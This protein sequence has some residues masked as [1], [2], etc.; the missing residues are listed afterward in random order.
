MTSNP[1]KQ[2]GRAIL[3]ATIF[4]LTLA[5]TFPRLGAQIATNVRMPAN[6]RG[7]QAIEALADR[8]PDVARAH[9]LDPQRLATMLRTQPSLGVDVEGRL[10]FAC[11]G[12]AVRPGAA[13]RDAITPSSSFAQ[14][15]AG[16]A[17]DVF[18]LH[19][20]PGATRVIYLDFTGHTTSGT[21]WN[22]SFTGGATIVSAPFDLDG[23]ST[24][25]NDAERGAILAIWKRVAEDYAPFLVDVTTQDPGVESLRKTTTGDLAY[26]IRVVISPTN[27]Y[28][29][30]AGG[31]AY[32]GSFSWNSDTPAWVFTNQLANDAGYI[33]EATSHE[34]GH[35][36]GLNHDGQGG[37]S[38]TE[39]Y[40]G[41][42]DWAPIMG[43][44]Y[45]RGIVQFSRG[46]YA[47]ANN[48]EDDFAI[49]ATH[50]PLASDDHGNN[51][52]TATV[53]SGAAI[54]D[55]GTIETRAD[56]DVFR[57]DTGNGAIAINVVSPS[58]SPNLLLK[59]ELLNSS[60]QVLLTSTPS[61]VNVSFT[62][63]LAAGS[64]FLR[65]SALGSGD[66]LTTGY[67]S[68]GSVGNYLITG[69]LVPTTARQ[70]PVAV[71]SASSVVGTGTLSVNFS[72]QNSTDADGAI[73]SYAWN[74]GN[75]ST[76]S[77]MNAT[78]LYTAPGTYNAV[79]T[80]T[81]ND[82]LTG[83]TTVVIT[84]NAAANQAPVAIISTN[85]NA[86]TAPVAIAFSGASS[87]DP[88]GSVASYLWNFGD[89]TTSTAVTPAK[90]YS[91][92]GN[93]TVTLRV[94]DNLGA[95]ATATSVVAIAADPNAA[96]DVRQYAL[97][98]ST[99][100]SGTK[101][102]ATISIR[103]RLDRPV[104]DVTVTVQ[105]SGLVTG[106]VSGKTNIDG[107]VVIASVRTKKAGT[108][109]GTITAVASTSGKYYDSL[110]YSEPT[111]R[112]VSVK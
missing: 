7:A 16:T 37:T 103:D 35:S 64:Y 14:I 78:C 97:T 50:A 70:A 73:T 52:A 100:S 29:P 79:L 67:S 102:A 45:Y 10:T 68:Y 38:P 74:F 106:K 88:D 105:W 42:G 12:L 51:L 33:A 5:G 47:N 8:L 81:D 90:T 1:V 28:N 25:F 44:G 22:S 9:G 112:V 83:S 55:G 18:Q 95:T 41:H 92:P 54:S 63:T 109:T 11:D 58:P 40:Y 85:Q 2:N 69:T 46:E 93:Y 17:V 86:G 94:T 71:A 65:L 56:V 75:G 48:T 36:M 99:S 80:V 4:A 24:T 108:I 23:D 60:G 39:Y 76:A 3:R 15:A 53:I 91:T 98:T 30:S 89:G 26:G 111:V 62:P 20:L 104:A 21:I 107:Q 87:Y 66:P 82:G 72:G 27:W 84:V 34:V 6:V 43:V 110:I 77:S 31:S 32:V 101:A 19:S 13:P 96:V 57:F 49:I 59:A 61:L